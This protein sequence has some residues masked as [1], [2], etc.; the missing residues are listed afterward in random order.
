MTEI[1][2]K[3]HKRAMRDII[4]MVVGGAVGSTVLYWGPMIPEELFP[5]V[6]GGVVVLGVVISTSWYY[7]MA[8][9]H[10]KNRLTDQDWADSQ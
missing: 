1:E 3:A 2:R 4:S 6:V 5:W 7:D 10:E 8:Y 9:R